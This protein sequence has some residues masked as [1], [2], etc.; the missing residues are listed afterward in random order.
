[1]SDER[2][3][4]LVADDET[5]IR[6]LVAERFE[7]AGFDVCQA[8]DGRA[9]VEL[10]HQMA[11]KPDLVLL[12]LMMPEMDGHEALSRLREI[13]DV[14]VI[15]LTARDAFEDKAKTFTCGADDYLTK[16]FSFP[17][18]ELRVRALLRRTKGKALPNQAA[19]TLRNGDLILDAGHMRAQ[20]RG[21]DAQLSDREYRLLSLLVSR[22]GEII[23]YAE[24]LRAGWPTD[25]DADTANLRVAMARIRKKLTQLGLTPRILASYTNVGYFM[26][27]LSDYDRDYADEAE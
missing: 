14:P 27:D 19:P 4:I 13:S 25:L 26:G 8:Q 20:W 2:P 21:V 11:V 16:P 18:L 10:F 9:A 5:R 3:L 15:I 22:P 24:L 17:E 7:A 12:D 6:R 23:R 1:M